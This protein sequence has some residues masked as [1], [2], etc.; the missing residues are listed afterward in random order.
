VPG[1]IGAARG[2]TMKTTQAGSVAIK[3]SNSRK[4]VDGGRKA[5]RNENNKERFERDQARVMESVSGF[6]SLILLRSK[7]V[8]IKE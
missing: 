1:A 3:P 5:K 2:Y 4:Q 8:S 6:A 7:Q